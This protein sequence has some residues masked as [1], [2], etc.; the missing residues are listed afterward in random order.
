MPGNS[1]Y[2]VALYF[3]Y[4]CLPCLPTRTYHGLSRFL[5]SWTI[6]T[7]DRDSVTEA[8]ERLCMTTEYGTLNKTAVCSNVSACVGKMFT[9][10]RVYLIFIVQKTM[11][12]VNI[13]VWSG[14]VFGVKFQR[15]SGAASLMA[16]RFR[17]MLVKQVIHYWRNCIIML[18]VMLFPVFETIFACYSA[19]LHPSKTDP[20]PLPLNL[21]YFDKSTVLFTS[22]GPGSVSLAKS[23][24]EV[25]SRYG[26]TRDVGKDNMDDSLL[27]IAKRSLEDYNKR[28]IVAATALSNGNDSL[29][30]HF[31]NFALHSIAISLSLVDNALL[32]YAVPGSPPIVTINHPLPRATSTQTSD[33]EESSAASHIS[34]NILFAFILISLFVMFMVKQRSTKSKHCQFVS[35]VNAVI[36]YLPAFIGDLVIFVVFS[37]LIVIVLLGFQV[38]AYSEWPVIR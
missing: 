22:V 14:A 37:V 29:I 20:P 35:G 1:Y 16:Q 23:Y 9:C 11:K 27:E 31:N 12:A 4:L 18:I 8:L 33:V 25:A 21:S 34:Q 3:H 36:Y 6:G 28:H 26:Q 13:N 5:K 32:L 19:T 17:A 15:K 2:V 38:D 24:S 30:G 10:L 7:K